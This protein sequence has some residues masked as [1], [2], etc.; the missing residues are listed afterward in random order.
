MKAKT[1]LITYHPYQTREEHCSIGALVQRED[2]KMRA[3][4]ASNLR[5][6]K[7]IDPASDFND[8]RDRMAELIEHFNETPTAWAAMRGGIGG[9]R[10]STEPGYFLY[11]NDADYDR[12]IRLLLDVM[13]EPRSALKAKDRKP[14][15]RLY[16]ELRR[17]FE[18]YGWL[19]KTASDIEDHKVVTQYPVS[20]DNDL[21]AEFA[22]K[23]GRL[24]V[25]ET[26][27]F[28]MGV[29]SSKRL[30]AQGKALVMDF[31]KDADHTA[32]CTAIVAAPDYSGIRGSMNMLGR[33]ADRV[34][35]Y[36]SAADMNALFS[37]WS[38]SM[39]R[40]MLPIPSIS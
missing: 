31:A 22:M 18:Q 30:E 40:P 25:V 15:S 20:L 14:Q 35:A 6:M 32:L 29:P 9:L 13:V 37:D 17:T 33:Y 1:Y 10:F 12:Q 34:V 16:L 36:D 38:T 11:N 4:L 2:G 19:G 26:I 24:Q 23:N 28:R 5:K 39:G 21:F 27:D 8:I 3:H 7:A